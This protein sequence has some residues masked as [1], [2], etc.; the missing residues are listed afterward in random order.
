MANSYLD[1]TGLSYFWGKITSWATNK[2]YP[3]TGGSLDGDIRFVKKEGQ[4][5]RSISFGNSGADGV[6]LTF[7]T[8]SLQLSGPEGANMSM[9]G[10]KVVSLGDP[11]LDGDAVN[12]KTLKERTASPPQSG[13]IGYV[14][15][16]GEWNGEPYLQ[17]SPIPKLT[18]VSATLLASG[19]S[20]N[21]QTLTVEGVVSGATSQLINIGFV[22]KLAADA[23]D[24][25]GLYCDQPG[26]NTLSFLCDYVPDKD[27]GLL[28]SIQEASE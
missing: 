24:D 6:S 7:S 25:F 1:K 20:N 18:I 8:N 11:S 4:V 5:A 12:Y 10:R 26:N 16:V 2:F 15:T 14:L 28:I 13:H 21:T 22:N 19:W 17:Y 3:K 27:I 23:W 9:S